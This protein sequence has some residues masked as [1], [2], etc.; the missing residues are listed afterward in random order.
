MH[1]CSFSV[2]RKKC[3]YNESILQIFSLE[4][5]INL[6]SSIWILRCFF[7]VFLT[8]KNLST[9]MC[10]LQNIIR[11]TIKGQAL[12]EECNI[13]SPLCITHL[14]RLPHLHDSRK[15]I[16]ISSRW[17]IQSVE[18]WLLQ[19]I[20]NMYC[21]D[22]LKVFTFFLYFKL[23]NKLKEVQ[24][25]SLCQQQCCHDISNNNSRKYASIHVIWTTYTVILL[26][27]CVCIA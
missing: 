15:C 25:A 5:G 7:M 24:I 21:M 20:S 4:L 1:T 10:E 26:C 27:A 19:H 13:I 9:Q 17:Y 23:N 16:S 14:L 18:I 3:Y 11:I 6:F 2:H 22:Y 8:S 12:M